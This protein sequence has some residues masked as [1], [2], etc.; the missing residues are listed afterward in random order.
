MPARTQDFKIAVGFRK[1]TGTGLTTQTPTQLQALLDS[2]SK[3]WNLRI[4]AFNLPIP[5]LKNESDAKFFGKGH[6][7]ATQLFALNSDTGME[8]P[9]FLTS[10]NWAQ[11]V[12]FFQ[13]GPTETSPD[14]GA[15]KYV[16]DMM[17]PRTDGVNLP[18]TN[19][20]A[21]IWD[22][23]IFDIAVMGMVLAGFSLRVQKG[24]GL[25]NTQL[26]TRWI[27]SGAWSTAHG[28]TIPDA[29][30]EVRLGSG[31]AVELIINGVDYLSNARFSDLEFTYDNGINADSGF[32]LG[33]GSQSG[34]DLRGRLRFGSRSMTLVCQVE[35]ETDSVEFQ[36]LLDQTSGEVSIK[37]Q[38]PLIAGTTHH[39]AEIFLPDTKIKVFR[40]TDVD[41]FTNCRIEL[42]VLYN[43]SYGPV[44]LTA[45][46]DKAAIGT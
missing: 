38:G 18:A 7:F 11:V 23:D 6:E 32:H 25:S 1:Q 16:G 30:P 36:N 3:L 13:N 45:I 29:Y 27:G 44:V 14:T 40:M 19:M 4:D 5:D 15:H 17:V 37:I 12:A 28:L 46:T 24:P 31:E 35:L 21:Q 2:S 22:G 9:S 42:E 20:V 10:Q 33:S 34:Y 26:T 41:G 43:N 8:W 39:Q